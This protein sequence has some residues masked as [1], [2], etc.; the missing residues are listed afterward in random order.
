ME[1]YIDLHTHSTASDGTLTPTELVALARKQHLKALALTDHDTTNGL[2]EATEAARGTDL[3]LIPGI[4]F[5]S[6]WQNTSVHIVGLDL[7]W[8]NTAFQEAL[9][10]FQRSREERNDKIIALLQKEGFSITKEALQEAFPNSTCTRANLA[11][12]L[13]DH[14][15]LNSIKEAFDRYLGDRAKCYV[16]RKDISPFQSIRLIHECGGIAVFA[17]PV[18]CKFSRQQLDSLVNELKKAG[19]DA[20]EVYYSSYHASEETAMAMLAKQHGL[21]FSGGSDFHGDN[22]PQIQ[23]GTGKGNL[24]I[25]YSVLKRLREA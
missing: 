22:K 1:E 5:S 21:E 6:T 19:L 13:V 17:H 16:P 23:L 18:L 4:E 10:G 20:L 7:D 14:H 24:K 8:K 15:E 25:P 12:F 2:E 9:I 3:E 11:R